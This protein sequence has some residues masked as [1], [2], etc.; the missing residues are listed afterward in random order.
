MEEYEIDLR[1]L[2][3]KLWRGKYFIIGVFIVAVLLAALY[4]FVYLD[5]VYESRATL[6]IE[7]IPGEVNGTDVVSLSLSGYSTFFSSQVVLNPLKDKIYGE[8]G[9]EKSTRSLTNSLSKELETEDNFLYVSFRDSNPE[10][11]REILSLWIDTYSE[12]LTSYILSQ[13]QSS[14]EQKE[15]TR[16]RTSQNF[17]EISNELISFQKEYNPEKKKSRLTWLEENLPLYFDELQKTKIELEALNK[18][19]FLLEDMVE[20]EEKNV[21]GIIRDID[22][23]I[24]EQYFRNLRHLILNLEE[25]SPVWVFLRQQQIDYQVRLEE[26]KN[27]KDDLE[28]LIADMEEEMGELQVKIMEINAQAQE[29]Q[30]RYDRAENNLIRA[31]QE[32]ETLAFFLE[33]LSCCGVSVVEEPYIRDGRVAPNHRLNLA[34]AGV[35]GIFLGTGGLLFYHFMRDEKKE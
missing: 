11:A 26:A 22:E 5:P 21:E 16:Q 18:A 13:N 31:I 6:R 24:Q 29:I 7:P 19:T 3:I 33:N 25:V 12:E 28:H 1:E 14:L 20:D 27:R 30:S 4:S 8:L 9:Q 32:Y 34:L 35:L 2:F 10:N 23:E 17:S 15:I